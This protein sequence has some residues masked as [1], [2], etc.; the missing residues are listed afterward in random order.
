MRIAFL[1]PSL[2]RS[3]GVDVVVRYAAAL[4]AQEDFDA[5]VV[6]VDGDSA[7]DAT[8]AP[9]RRL[10]QARG[11]SWDLAIATWW[12]TARALP[13]LKAARRALFVQGWEERF[14]TREK[15]ADR[16]GAALSLAPCD[17]AIAVSEHVARMVS[18]AF[19]E[20]PLHVVVN[21]IDK[22]VFAPRERAASSGPL[23]VLL[24]GQPELAVKGFGQALEALGLMAEPVHVTHVAL[25]PS[26]AVAADRSLVGL[27]PPEMADAYAETDVLLKLSRAEGL[28]L[29]P[30]EAAHVGV[31][32]IL[33]PFGG[34]AQWLEH[35]RNGIEV[36]WDDVPG[37]AAWLD[38]LA[39]DRVLLARLGDGAR[40]TA[41]RWPAQERQVGAMA[42]ACRAI[43]ECDPLPAA[44]GARY[45]WRTL[46][47]HLELTRE[48]VQRASHEL[49]E[50]AAELEIERGLLRASREEVS[51]LLSQVDRLNALVGEL[52]E[53]R[54]LVQ[55]RLDEVIASRAYRAAV[56]LRRLAR[57]RG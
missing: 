48:H 49:G 22:D 56:A 41:E 47:R 40:A 14:Y 9:V 39:R 11:E 3:G 25:Q 29:P 34:Q 30:L 57:R 38:V 16:L 28:G 46:W 18:A 4:R 27:G 54:A 12:T 21:G 33:T 24:E 55:A 2:S 13:E 42:T 5:Q 26:A 45:A 50:Q 17:G 35:G 8:P 1:L 44:I 51:E 7:D 31:P 20:L 15:L 36:G 52:F 32:S 19:P 43:L 6:L 10:A 53:A 37:T 23:R